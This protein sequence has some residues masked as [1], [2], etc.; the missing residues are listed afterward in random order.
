MHSF[1]GGLTDAHTDSCPLLCVLFFEDRL[2]DRL[3]LEPLNRGRH[4]LGD[5][6]AAV[7]V[8]LGQRPVRPSFAQ[9]AI[10]Q[11]LALCLASVGVLL[12]HLCIYN[13]LQRQEKAIYEVICLQTLEPRSFVPRQQFCIIV[14]QHTKNVPTVLAVVEWK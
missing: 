4:E 3:W 2:R 8:G 6:L 14:V 13:F 5:H 1:E 10:L 7:L 11:P 12:R 9:A